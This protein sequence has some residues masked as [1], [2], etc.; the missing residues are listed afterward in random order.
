MSNLGIWD[1]L[2]DVPAS[3]QKKIAAGRLKGFTDISPQWRYHIT[4]ETFGPIGI[5]WKYT[6]DRQWI[7]EGSYEQKTAFTN[8]SLFVKQED[9]EWSDAIPGTGG[10]MYIAEE[11]KTDYNTKEKYKY[12]YTSDEAFK[13]S[14]T[15]ALSVAL[16]M[17]GV[18]A[19]I[20]SSGNDYS[21]YS[22]PQQEKPQGQPKPE[23]KTQ[24][25]KKEDWY[26]DYNKDKEG[27]AY[28]IKQGKTASQIIN[29]ILKTKRI[30]RKTEAAIM[31]LEERAKASGGGF[32]KFKQDSSE[33]FPDEVPYGNEPP[34]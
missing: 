28:D 27:F 13:M 14:L 25:T 5:G 8:I 30:S 23:N 29:E 10:S 20:Y 3:A 15:D 21:K 24:S 26:N 6:I 12:L 2:K 11:N 18:G 19:V 7:E 22:A 31:G 9:G 1:K 16:K 32:D 4:T 17:L 34:Q 33:M